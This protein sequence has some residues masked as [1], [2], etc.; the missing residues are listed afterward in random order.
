MTSVTV[1]VPVWNGERYLESCIAALLTQSRPPDEIL[2][3]DN[4]STD[5][6]RI[7]ADGLAAAEPTVRVMHH[8]ENI[9]AAENFNGLLSASDADFFAWCAHDDLWS[10]PLL[11]QMIAAHDAPGVAIAYGTP[12]FI[13]DSGSPT[14]DPS[15]SF[16]TDSADPV[17]RLRELFDDPMH[18]HLH[19][20]NPVLGLMRRDLLAST[21]AIRPYGGSDKVLIVEMALRGRL[22]PVEAPFHRRVHATSSVRAN[23][24]DESR[25]RWFDPTATG[26]ATPESK[27]LGGFWSAVGDA[28]LTPA[29]RRAARSVILRWSGTGRRPRV[30]FGEARHLIGWKVRRGVRRLSRLVRP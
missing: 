25:R 21:G 29:Q 3:S 27:L 4:A 26:P 14:V 12:A 2:I 24:D 13:D 30:L 7:I 1:G 10:P 6:S 5:R 8:R 18:S 28:P 19:V 17:V 11:S 16:W 22:V 23:P 15:A 20:C 9:G